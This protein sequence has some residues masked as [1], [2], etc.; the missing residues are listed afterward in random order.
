MPIKVK[1]KANLFTL[2]RTDFMSKYHIRFHLFTC[3]TSLLKSSNVWGVS[4]TCLRSCF[5][6]PGL[7]C[8]LTWS[9]VFVLV[10]CW[11][12]TLL[13]RQSLSLLNGTISKMTSLALVILA[14]LTII[15]LQ[16]SAIVFYTHTHTQYTTLLSSWGNSCGSSK[17]NIKNP[18]FKDYFGH[19]ELCKK[20]HTLRERERERASL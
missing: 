18:H 1:K 2:P 5:L 17:Q 11:Q 12:D 15:G 6:R 9:N 10:L 3:R 13:L 14:E 19:F 8:Y 7:L 4:K 16:C 20:A